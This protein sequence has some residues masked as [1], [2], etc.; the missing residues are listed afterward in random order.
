MI[1]LLGFGH[2]KRR[3]TVLGEFDAAVCDAQPLWLESCIVVTIPRY[4]ITNSLS[5]SPKMLC[6]QHYTYF[7]YELPYMSSRRFDATFHCDQGA[8]GDRTKHDRS[9]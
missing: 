7:V 3:A 8:G 5:F 2:D 4:L 9:R 1:S 6:I